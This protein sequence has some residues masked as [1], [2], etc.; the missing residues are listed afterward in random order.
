MTGGYG[1]S[2][3]FWDYDTVGCTTGGMCNSRLTLMDNGN[4]GIGTTVPIR[5]L[6]VYGETSIVPNA[7]NGA[8]AELNVSDTTGSNGGNYS[9]NIRGLANNG[10]AGV[11]L[12]SINLSASNVGIGTTTPGNPLN[13]YTSGGSTPV[14]AMSIDVGTFGTY[15]NATS[16]YFLR[17]RDIGGSST[18]FQIQ[19][20]GNVGIGTTTPAFNLDVSGKI[21]STAGVVYPDGTQQTTAWTGVLCGGDY[22]ESVNVKGDRTNYGPGDVLVIDPDDPGRFLKSAEPYS[23]AVLG[24]YSTKPGALGRRQTTPKGTDEVPMAMIGIVPTKVSVENGAIKPGDLL[25]TSSTPGYAMKGT[26]R[27]RLVGAIIGK[28]MGRLDAGTGVIEV[29]V[30][31]Q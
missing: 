18:Y 1:N 11:N 20:N 29:G 13:L 15:S 28:A 22:A 16:S 31:L 25:V 14:G 21:R 26:D 7:V 9:I 30:T 23:S 8:Y 2:L 5:A 4:V 12:A 24:I 17:V 10:T 6:T 27:S 3:Q 19:G